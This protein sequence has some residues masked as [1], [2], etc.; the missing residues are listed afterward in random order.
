MSNSTDNTHGIL[1]IG[2][3]THPHDVGSALVL[4]AQS[5]NLPLAVANI[6]DYESSL[7]HLWGKVFYRI[8]QR[9]TLEWF[10]FQRKILDLIGKFQPQLVIVTGI[11]PLGQDIFHTIHNYQGKI[12]NYLTDNPWNPALGSPI[13][14]DNLRLYDCVFST[15]TA[16]IPQLLRVG[17]RNLFSHF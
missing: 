1:I 15:K 12:V 10:D 4:A 9:R 14:R 8:A 16:I 7:N 13:F 5:L 11:I 6:S 3:T 17:V 2:F